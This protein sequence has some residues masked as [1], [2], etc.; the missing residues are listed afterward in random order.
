M[1]SRFLSDRRGGFSPI[2]S[3]NLLPIIGAAGIAVD[4]GRAV[5][6]RDALQAAAD[7]TALAVIRPRY[8]RP[9]VKTVA[10]SFFDA[11]RREK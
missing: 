6:T 11:Q 9:E 7:A 8:S 4:Y 10:K 1:L 5:Y 2:F 3:L